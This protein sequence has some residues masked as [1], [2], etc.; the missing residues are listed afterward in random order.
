M[1]RASQLNIGWTEEQVKQM[2]ASVVEGHT[3]HARKEEREGHSQIWPE[4]TN[5]H[6]PEFRAAIQKRRKVSAADLPPHPD[7]PKPKWQQQRQWQQHQGHRNLVCV[8]PEPI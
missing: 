8:E 2:D 3:Y 5:A 7:I 1:Y 4:C 6:H